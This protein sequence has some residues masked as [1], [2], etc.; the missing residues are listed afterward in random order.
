MR[1]I[2]EKALNVCGFDSRNH[3]NKATLKP[4]FFRY[5]QRPDFLPDDLFDLTFGGTDYAWVIMGD[6]FTGTLPHIDPDL[7]AAWNL[8]VHG[9]KV[10]SNR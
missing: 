5:W 7:T 2:F 1:Y 9:R 4:D 3:E 6:P 10:S 8:L